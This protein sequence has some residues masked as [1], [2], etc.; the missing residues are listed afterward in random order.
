MSPKRQI[1]FIWPRD[2]QPGNPTKWPFGKRI[3]DVLR[4]RGPDMFIG[5]L[6]GPRVGPSRARWSRW[7]DVYPADDA[8]DDLLPPL[9]RCWDRKQQRYDFRTR[10]YK[11]PDMNTW[12]YVQYPNDDG[13]G[14][15]RIPIAIWDQ[16][17]IQYPVEPWQINHDE[18]V[19]L[20][21]F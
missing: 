21:N 13:F 7:A 10:K 14:D 3:M 4:N 9:F 5:P 19:N 2:P 16:M 1:G 20:N 8:E 11:I 17:G 6:D 12:S 15:I 18:I